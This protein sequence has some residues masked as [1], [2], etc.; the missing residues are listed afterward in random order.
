MLGEKRKASAKAMSK[1]EG[2]KPANSTNP[3]LFSVISQVAGRSLESGDLL[4]LL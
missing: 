2:S 1:N 3:A 4:K